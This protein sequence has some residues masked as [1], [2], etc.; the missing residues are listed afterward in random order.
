LRKRLAIGVSIPAVVLFI[1]FLIA[2]LLP[3]NMFMVTGALDALGL[4]GGRERVDGLATA[5]P[6]DT[7]PPPILI[8][9]GT[10]WDPRDGA[11]PNTGLALAG[12]AI[13]GEADPGPDGARVID[14]EGMTILPGLIDMHVHAMGGSFA[15]E[16]MAG[17]GVVT[18]R[19]LGSNL[20]GILER[21]AEA[22]A[23]RR[24]GPRLFVTGPYLVGGAAASDQE[25]S[26][27]DA[28]AAV[29]VVD[30]FADAGAD[31]IKVHWGI[32]TEVLRAVVAA[33]HARGLWV[34]AHLDRVDATDAARAGIDTIEHLS[35]FDW[36]APDPD[37]AAAD[38]LAAALLENGTAVTST[39]VVAEHAFTLPE[40]ARGDDPALAYF[41]WLTRRFWISSQLAN[42]S[43]T[44][45][46]PGETQARRDRLERMMRFVG[47][48]HHAG[49]RVL[50]GT[51]AP[52]F[53]VAPG[54]DLH[55]ELEL[56]VEA[57]LSPADALTAATGAAAA[58]LGQ[59]DRLGGTRAGMR[60]DLVLVEGDPL[61]DIA[62]TRDIRMVIQGGHILLE[63]ER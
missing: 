16:M 58:S 55:R 56:L 34:A 24:I 43:A 32:D 40:L 51:D 39:L 41:P 45:L 53:L 10:L 23:G 52:A 63:R 8:V 19:D 20:A 49:G 37:G 30:R 2:L 46:T 9:H 14:A 4:L 47:L 13:L 60:A 28:A 33:A 57:G 31:G 12:G 29:E 21:R 27:A 62:A 42:A 22:A 54:F 61:S 18:A 1:G 36:D 38:R 48:F 15:D 3:S 5:P 11:R 59:G 26:V 35:G 6:G 50:A 44:H 17:N 25:I 7:P